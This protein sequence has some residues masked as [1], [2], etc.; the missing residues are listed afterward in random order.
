MAIRKF[1]LISSMLGIVLLFILS[2][3]TISN[4]PSSTEMEL[5]VR[6]ATIS[7]Y[8]L[9]YFN[10]ALFIFLLFLSN[11]IYFRLNRTIYLLYTVLIFLVF[12][13]FY[14]FFINNTS[15]HLIKGTFIGGISLFLVVFNYFLLKS[16]FKSKSKTEKD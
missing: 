15:H 8:L 3:L 2:F 1:F 9:N 16:Y 5:Q 7:S 4:M 6:V 14:W 12:E 13:G 10:L 11:I